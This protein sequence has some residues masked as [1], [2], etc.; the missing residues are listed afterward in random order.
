MALVVKSTPRGGVS[1]PG[2]PSLGPSSFWSILYGFGMVF[3][4]TG[5]RILAAGRPRFVFSGLGLVLLLVAIAARL[6]RAGRCPADRRQVERRFLW[7]YLLGLAAVAAYVIQSDL[8][9]LAGFAGIE[10]HS[11]KLGVVLAALWPVIWSVALFAIV[12]MEL[13]YAPMK[14]APRIETG[15]VRAA[16]YAGMGLAFIVTLAFSLTYAASERDKKLDLAYFRTARPGESTRKIV[17]ALDVPLTVAVFF[18]NGNEVREQVDSYLG[19]LARESSQLKIEHYDFDIDPVKARELG[20][21]SNGVLVFARGGRKEQFGLQLQVEAARTNLRVLDREVQQ[22][23]LSVAKPNRVTFLTQGHGER[24][25][26]PTS[27]SDHRPGIRELR[28]ALLDQGHDVRDL[29]PA[30]GLATDV[31]KDAT[32]VMVIGPTKPFAAEE[33]GALRRFLERG[34]RIFLALDP[35]GG[36]SMN[37]LLQPTG[38]KL[39]LKPLANDQVYA[40]RTHQDV[41][42]ANLVS[43]LYSAHPSVSTLSRQGTR[44]PVVLPGAT[45]IGGPRPHAPPVDGWSVDYTVHAN[46][47]TFEDDNGNF[48]FDPGEVRKAWELAAAASKTTGKVEQRIFV[49][50]DSDFLTDPV[51]RFAGNGLLVLD[52]VRWLMGEESFA[53]QLSSEADVPI[54]HTRKQDVAWFYSSIFVA[55]GVVLAMGFLVTRRK[56]RPLRTRSAKSTLAPSEGVAS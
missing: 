45:A 5:E 30:E 39:S 46:F 1:Q 21:S 40:S 31:P 6:V 19:D 32:V 29:G 15:R 56:R 10:S 2:I 25:A 11:I 18:P 41:D 24:T 26:D 28:N 53:G 20:V 50:G 13:S 42:R 43:A 49:V 52:P 36:V 22:R 17:R 37:E 3:L 34:G 44:A 9:A 51:I 55:P 33:I 35:E 4:F 38:L 12:P 14:R 8:P 47:S 16:Q 27:D 23:L 7:M 54:S 48:K